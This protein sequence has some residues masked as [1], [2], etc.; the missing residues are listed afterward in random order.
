MRLSCLRVV[1]SAYFRRRRHELMRKRKAPVAGYRSLESKKSRVFKRSYKLKGAIFKNS[2][3]AT[4]I[5]GRGWGGAKEKL[6]SIGSY[7]HCVRIILDSLK[8]GR[9]Q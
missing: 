1:E 2:F 8:T 4:P 3:S 9:N 5:R 6:L 7:F